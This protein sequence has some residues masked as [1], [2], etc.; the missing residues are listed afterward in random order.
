MSAF[1]AAALA[2]TLVYSVYLAFGT[3]QN[4]RVPFPSNALELYTYIY[5]FILLIVRWMAIGLVAGGVIPALVVGMILYFLLRKKFKP[6]LSISMIIGGLAA[7]TQTLLFEIFSS[8]NESFQFTVGKTEIFKDGFRTFDGWISFAQGC[9][10]TFL[11]G[12][13]GGI[14][15]WWIVK[16][17]IDGRSRQLA[18]PPAHTPFT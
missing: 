13:L 3:L 17:K 6:R 14:M 2:P 7:N 18:A 10:F 16:R 5:N 8:R 4:W 11:L 12:A 1:V 9:L 15:F